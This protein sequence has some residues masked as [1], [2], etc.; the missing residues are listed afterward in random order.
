M[1]RLLKVIFLLTVVLCPFTAWAAPKAQ[2]VSFSTRDGW[3]IDGTYLPA[4]NQNTVILLHDLNQDKSAFTSLQNDLSNAGI[5]YLAIDLR[6]HGKSQNKG[7]VRSFEREGVDNQFNKMTQDVQAAIDFLQQK[8]VP[9]E[10]IALIGVGLGANV[11]AKSAVLGGV[12]LL[13]LISPATNIRDVLVIPSMRLYKGD[14]LIGAGAADKKGF[15]EASVIRNVAFLTTGEGKVTF[16]TAYDL[17]SHELLDKYLRPALVQWIKTPHKPDVLPDAPFAINQETN[18]D[19]I[20]IAPSATEE[21]L[22]PSV[23]GGK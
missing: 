21:A 4:N 7:N 23:L 18:T 9:S 11:A 6:G 14:V 10:T 1:S 13:G 12:G 19:G 22:V 17:T 3:I 20:A 5:G 8:R 16:L 2:A 15:L